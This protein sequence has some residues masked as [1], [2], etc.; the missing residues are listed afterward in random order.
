MNGSLWLGID[1][2]TQGVRALV[3]GRGGHIEGRGTATFDVPPQLNGVMTHDPRADWMGGTAEAV[4]R[5]IGSLDPRQIGAVGVCGLFPASVLLDELGEPLGSAI[6]YGDTRAAAFAPEVARRLGV[7][8]S[9]DEV[10]PR[11]A[12]LRHDYPDVFAKAARIVGPT[13]YVVQ[14]LTGCVTID[15]HSAHRWGGLTDA[16][17]AAWADNALDALGV[18]R[19]LMPEIVEPHC[20]VGQVTR[21]AAELTGLTTGTPVVGGT[22]DS[23]ATFVGHGAVRTRDRIVYYGSTWTAMVATCDLETVLRQPAV[24]D[25][26][27]PWRLAAYAV[28]AGRFLEQLRVAMFRGRTYQE[29][30][31]AAAAIPPGARGVSVIP[32]PSARYDG[33]QMHSSRAAILG[34][35]MDHGS[36]EVWRAALES[37]GHIVASG[38]EGAT[39]A[40]GWTAAAGTGARSAAWRRIVS[41]VANLEQR[42]DPRASAALGAAFLAAYGLGAVKSLDPVAEGWLSYDQ[43]SLTTPDPGAVAAYASERQAWLRYALAVAEMT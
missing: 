39:D 34:F 42:Y 30:D 23:F 13:G 35:G 7:T 24:I 28:D 32:L 21:R 1:L 2:G 9:G 25:A 17:R 26:G 38:L 14:L 20:V 19:T 18:P 11:L 8:L 6:L 43:A 4:R 12:W 27:V 10:S 41:D 3:V 36:D 5:A 22:T 31:S 29:L 37:M 15:P 33:S 16:T 40:G